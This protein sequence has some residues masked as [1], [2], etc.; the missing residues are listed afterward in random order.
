MHLNGV[1]NLFISSKYEDVIPLKMDLLIS[2]ICHGKF[3]KE[4]IQN[5]ELEILENLEFD[6]CY[7]NILKFVEVFLTE[8]KPDWGNFGEFF[9][10][11]AIYL[12]K[13]VIYDYE[14]L[15]K[16]K[17]S[18]L[19]AGVIIVAFKMIQKLVSEF[20]ITCYV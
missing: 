10:K 19:A 2:K 14:I 17:Y 4:D 5:Q 6:L 18:F 16:H 1:T 7:P 8:I 3:T 15:S 9:S 11:I 13:M 20:S 12:S